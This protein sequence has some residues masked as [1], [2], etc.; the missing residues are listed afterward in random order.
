MRKLRAVQTPPSASGAG[1]LGLVAN[2]A[3]IPGR[4]R[5][6]GHTITK[7]NRRTS[8]GAR[9]VSRECCP[10]RKTASGSEMAGPGQDSNG[11]GGKE[12]RREWKGFSIRSSSNQNCKTSHDDDAP[13]R[14]R[15]AHSR[16]G[17][18]LN[19]D[20]RGPHDNRVGRADARRQV[21]DS[22]RGQ[23][24]DQDRWCS[25]RQNRP[26]HMR[27][28]AGQHRT[29]VHVAHARSWLH[30]IAPKAGNIRLNRSRQQYSVR[31]ARNR[32]QR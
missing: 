3:E 16:R 22:R 31:I 28:H 6:S 14:S 2:F 4:R 10:S 30:R 8:C 12:R 25:W 32:S 27:H 13:V 17:H 5:T 9:T 29:D 21:T 26:A 1:K 23:A 19:K 18:S 24:A 11:Q 20:S 15:I 7:G